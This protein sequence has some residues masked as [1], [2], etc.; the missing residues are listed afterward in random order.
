MK[1][2]IEKEKFQPSFLSIFYHPFF[3]VRREIYSFLE[4]NSNFLIGKLLD[5]GC[6]SKPYEKLFKNSNNYVGVEVSSNKE[7]LKSDIYYNGI[8]LPFADNSFDSVLCTE[9]FEHVEQL[10]DVIIELYRVLKPG[11]RMIVTT[12]FMCVEHEMPYDFRRFTFNGLINFMKKNNFKI[13]KAQKLLNNFHVFFQTLNFYICKV[14]LKK[15]NKFLRYFVYFGLAGPVNLLSLLA[16]F[17]L[18]KIN[19]MYF[20]SGMVVEK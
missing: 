3:F 15:K 5:F 17:L 12:P 16:N 14:F 9:V 2:Y 6:G 7:N 8:A 13:L 10:D 20:G 19:E 11:G 18:P 4:L 1:N